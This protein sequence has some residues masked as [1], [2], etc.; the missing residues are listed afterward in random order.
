MT[1]HLVIPDTQV[2]PGVDI[3]YL[4]WIGNFI[5]EV[6]PDVIVQIGDWADMHSLA[7][8]DMG[9][10]AGEGARYQHDIAA[11]RIAMDVLLAPMN[12]YNAR[13]SKFHKAQYK[14]RMVLTLGNHENRISRHVESY[15]YLDGHLSVD[16]LGYDNFGWEVYPFLEAV[17]IDGVLYSHFFPRSA[18][19]RI[20]QQRNGA[21]NAKVQVQREGQ[22]CTAGHLQGLDWYVHNTGTR[23]MY[24]LIA[25]SCY[26]HDEDYLTP[27]GTHYWR[28]VIVKRNVNNGEYD[29]SF[30]SLKEL[31]EIYG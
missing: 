23:I 21:T 5:M 4:E 16:D 6:R 29:P 14:P 2:K 13:Q 28:G 26:T 25:G 19:G 22:S 15:A 10:R 31:Q 8:Y 12:E 18:N 17:D 24:G 11:A 1:T 9:R 27:Q 30:H 20:M 7:S 3:S